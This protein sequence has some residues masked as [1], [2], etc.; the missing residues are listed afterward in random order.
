MSNT[1]SIRLIEKF[2][3]IM[4]AL[5]LAAFF[6]PLL[7][8]GPFLIFIRAFSA[9]DMMKMA[10][11][12]MC[13]VGV[14]IF[15]VIIPFCLYTYYQ[16]AI[17]K[18]DGSQASVVTTNRKLKNFE[19]ISILAINLNGPAMFVFST[20]SCRIHGIEYE[21]L[22]WFLVAEGTTFLFGLLMYIPFSEI[23]EEHIHNLPIKREYIT[24]SVMARNSFITGF[25]FLGVIFLVL[26]PM[27]SKGNADLDTMPLF[28]TRVLPVLIITSVIAIL[29]SF[30]FVN[31]MN[32]RIRIITKF[33]SYLSKNDYTQKSLVVTSRD[34]FGVLTADLNQFYNVMRRLLRAIMS[35]VA[36]STDSAG[37]LA[38]GV[39]ETS[40]SI[41]QIVANIE[42][43]KSRIVNQAAGVEE[44][45]AT[46]KSMVEYINDLDKNIDREKVSIDSSSTA[47]EQMVANIR[48]VTN[49]LKASGSAAQKLSDASNNGR[50]AIEQ[51]VDRARDILERSE[52]LL[53]ASNIIQSIADQTNLLAM[54]AAIEA[55]H[56]GEAGKGFSVVSDEIRKLAEQS[57]EQ[58]KTI[59][60]QLQELQE[61]IQQVS[62]G[63]TQ[64]KNQFDTIFSL[65]DDVTEQN[66][67]VM[68][69]MQEQ[70]AGS[71]QVL[72]AMT[73]IK[74]TIELV[75]KGSA[76][77]TNG[78]KQIAA[79]MTALANLT[80]EINGA[81]SEMSSG[82][83]SIIHSVQ[84]V[85]S[86]TT[87][88]RDNVQ[89]LSDEINTF[90]VNR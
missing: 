86:A 17:C 13:F 12:P 88:N 25:S 76:E 43:V 24:L 38:D 30:L 89:K 80:E 23:L 9:A 37:N 61:S 39:S 90:T 52:G 75:A 84:S 60:E 47:V 51:A 85:D 78:G 83:Q 3:P 42:S 50:A 33:S 65:A 2:T 16:N 35:T 81:M 26:S 1:N 54:N 5:F 71:S 57:N 45:Q 70:S 44:A 14:V 6:L 74:S 66:R 68:S 77:L 4:R 48:S 73:E 10:L 34:D 64:V 11:A 87:A 72:E 63:T 67:T 29:D 32:K 79:E 28:L 20:I 7:T 18:Y 15:N 56:A 53:E 69:A 27:F 49:T 55:A 36:V 19:T 41:M 21:P 40:S 58:G 31:S 46:V 59:S 22:V 8:F 62:N 82:A